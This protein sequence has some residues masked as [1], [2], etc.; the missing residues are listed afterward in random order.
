MIIERYETYIIA[1]VYED[2]SY[3]ENLS[4]YLK[5]KFL[6]FMVLLNKPSQHATSKVY[7]FVPTQD[8]S[9]KWNDTKL[10]KKYNFTCEEIKFIE[11]MI[12]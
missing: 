7:H 12:K 10:Y 8:F 11:S 9:Y 3:A 5:S 1:G 4:I 2:K 6:R